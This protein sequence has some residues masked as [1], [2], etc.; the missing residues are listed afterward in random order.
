MGKIEQNYSKNSENDR[1]SYR[2]ESKEGEA[3]LS[4]DIFFKWIEFF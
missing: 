4:A 1:K 3:W 2:I